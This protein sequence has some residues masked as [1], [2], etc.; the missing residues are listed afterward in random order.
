MQLPSNIDLEKSV[1]F[2]L[3]IWKS[4]PHT[5]IG[6]PRNNRCVPG[7]TEGSAPISP[8]ILIAFG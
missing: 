8:E 5:G 6:Y 4:K 7:T 2:S 1:N 3:Y